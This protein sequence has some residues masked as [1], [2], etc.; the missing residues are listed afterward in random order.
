[1][2]TTLTG[3]D[4]CD[5]AREF[6][7][8]RKGTGPGLVSCSFP[9]HGERVILTY[10]YDSEPITRESE[11]DGWHTYTVPAGPAVRF[12]AVEREMVPVVQAYGKSRDGVTEVAHAAV[13]L[14][15]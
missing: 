2:R 5:V 12:P 4:P 1:V 3:A 14:L 15:E 8:G 11:Y 7:I 13:D 10:K 9:F 6:G